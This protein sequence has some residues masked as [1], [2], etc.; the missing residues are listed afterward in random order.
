[1]IKAPEGGQIKTGEKTKKAWWDFLGWAGTADKDETVQ[2][3]V[4][5]QLLAK[6]VVDVGNRFGPNVRLEPIT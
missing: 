4:N 5:G 6:R 1:M 3:D 2:L